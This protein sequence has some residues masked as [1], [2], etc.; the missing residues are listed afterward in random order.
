MTAPLGVGRRIIAPLVP[1]FC[2]LFPEVDIRLRLSD[3]R[4]DMFEDEQDVAFFLG[5]PQDS[6]LKMRKIAD[7]PR[8]LCATPDYL[9]RHGTPRTPQDLLDSGQNCLLLRFP[10]S[11]E[12]FWVL[13]TPD[14]PQ[15]LEVAGRFDADTHDVLLD[16][17]LYGRGIAMKPRF[18]VARHLETGTLVEILPDT[19]PQPA[20]FGCLYP[21]RKLQDPKIQRFLD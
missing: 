10:R 8:L 15:K 11:P 2:D 14:G 13:D 16:W 17:A 9:A 12:Y 18:E 20:V 4:V 7:C 21:H 6:T 5:T 19:P 1:R 3:R